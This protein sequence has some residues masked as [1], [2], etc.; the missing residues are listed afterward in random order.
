MSGG[1]ANWQRGLQGAGERHGGGP[2]VRARDSGALALAG[3]ILLV[4]LVGMAGCGGTDE[5]VPLP[6]AAQAPTLTLRETLDLIVRDARYWRTLEST[7]HVAIRS[8]RFDV[9]R[10]VVD[11][12]NGKLT[13]QKPGKV[14]LVIPGTGTVRLKLVGDGRSYRVEMPV[15][16]GDTYSGN[17]GEPMSVQPSRVQFVPAEVVD[18][19]S[20]D[21]LLAGRA[22]TLTHGPQLS[23]VQSLEFVDDPE[24]AIRPANLIA[25]D[26]TSHRIARV[27]KYD[28]DGSA[29]ASIVFRGWSRVEALPGIEEKTAIVPTW[30]HI[31]YYGDQTGITIRLEDVKLNVEVDQDLFEVEG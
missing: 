14:H 22:Q 31:M 1:E 17:Y 21:H 24:P 3:L 19:L 23:T 25:F 29:R 18:A 27:D 11:L 12:R 20:P 4:L 7:C 15:F 28:A 2:A 26:R 13:V 30:F 8:S 9:P 16:G 10:N 5:V 6:A